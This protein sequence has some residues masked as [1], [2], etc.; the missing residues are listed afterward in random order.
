[1]MPS[2][3]VGSDKAT[4]TENREIGRFVGFRIPSVLYKMSY[5]GSPRPRDRSRSG[6]MRTNAPD[7]S[8]DS[9]NELP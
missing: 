5:R 6:Y 3:I 9:R 1:M 7:D 8:A 4:K 2:S